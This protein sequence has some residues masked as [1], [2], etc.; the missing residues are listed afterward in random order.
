MWFTHKIGDT[1]HIYQ[2]DLDEACFQH[3]MAYGSY[4]DLVKKKKKTESDKVL[5]IK[6]SKL[7]VIQNMMVMKED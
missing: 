7:L 5:R 6:R 2:N 1:C 3:D 4:K